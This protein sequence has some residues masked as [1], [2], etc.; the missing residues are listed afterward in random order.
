MMLYLLQR[1]VY[2]IP[3]RGEALGD[4]TDLEH[5]CQS[6]VDGRYVHCCHLDVD[7]NEFIDCASYCCCGNI[8]TGKCLKSTIVVY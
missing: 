5:R 7:D 1:P 6:S 2:A 4:H 8:A 3:I